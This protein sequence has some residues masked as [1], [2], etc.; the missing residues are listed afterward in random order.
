MIR[1]YPD[2]R[3]VSVVLM[4]DRHFSTAGLCPKGTASGVRAVE[5]IDGFLRSGVKGDIVDVFLEM[6][7]NGLSEFSDIIEADVA[8]VSQP[9]IRTF[10]DLVMRGCLNRNTIGLCKKEYPHGR[11]HG[12]D[13]RYFSG[14]GDALAYRDLIKRMPFTQYEHDLLLSKSGA[15]AL[16]KELDEMPTLATALKKIMDMDRLKKQ[17]RALD[18]DTLRIIRKW[19]T[20]QFKDRVDEDRLDDRIRRATNSLKVVLR[21]YI[22]GESDLMPRIDMLA[23]D[24][25][26]S[27]VDARFVLQLMQMDAYTAA[28]LFRKYRNGP[29]VTRALI[30]AGMYHTDAYESLFRMLQPRLKIVKT[31][32][33]ATRCMRVP[34]Q[35]IDTALGSHPFR[36]AA[37]PISHEWR[38]L[39]I[40]SAA[41]LAYVALRNA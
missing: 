9:L 19:I 39:A 2:V 23:T 14:S 24:L 34:E 41:L 16:L 3:G 13:F 26:S 38:A 1:A 8:D 11:V 35:V 28:R 15:E 36:P 17:F 37:S 5:F 40:V 30:Y 7:P 4:G 33:E 32:P 25:R 21:K 18:R 22:S 20:K 27:L 6:A 29:P 10:R 12:V 31:V